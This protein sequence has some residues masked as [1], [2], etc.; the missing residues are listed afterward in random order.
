VLVVVADEVPVGVAVAVVDA[1]AVKVKGSCEFVEEGFC[2]ELLAAPVDDAPFDAT[3]VNNEFELPGL[4]LE[5]E[6][7]RAR[8]RLFPPNPSESILF[9]IAPAMSEFPI[10]LISIGIFWALVT[11]SPAI[12]K[13]SIFSLA[14][15]S[16]SKPEASVMGGMKSTCVGV[17]PFMF[18][19]KKFI[20]MFD[21]KR[22]TKPGR[23]LKVEGLSIDHLLRLD[24]AENDLR[25]LQRSQP[26]QFWFYSKLFWVPERKKF[27]RS[28]WWFCHDV[29]ILASRHLYTLLNKEWKNSIS[30]VMNVTKARN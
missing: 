14:L 18:W 23:P 29:R 2:N 16:I 12:C 10:E 11:T 1:V 26:D 27:C 28:I 3:V 5:T 13:A 21:V 6:V 20:K 7:L 25:H 30:Q 19:K 17:T 24:S 15:V 22:F 4:V 8:E 9:K